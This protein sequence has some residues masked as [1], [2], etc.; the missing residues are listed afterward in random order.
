MSIMAFCKLVNLQT[1]MLYN[2]GGCRVPAQAVKAIFDSSPDNLHA[3]WEVLEGKQAFVLHCK[4]S[5]LGS[6][7]RFF[8]GCLGLR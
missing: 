8:S 7:L 5:Q 4:D 2:S 6:Q 1:K 3:F